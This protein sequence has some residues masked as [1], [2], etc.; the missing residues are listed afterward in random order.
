[1][2][3][4]NFFQKSVRA[5][6]ENCQWYLLSPKNSLSNHLFSNFF[7]IKNRKNVTFTK[8]FPRFNYFH[9]FLVY[10]EECDEC[11]KHESR[12]WRGFFLSNSNKNRTETWVLLKFSFCH[13][14]IFSWIRPSHFF[15][16]CW[17]DL[18]HL[19]LLPSSLQKK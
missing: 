11:K 9:E 5:H 14:S 6:F 10:T 4:R 15:D 16:A 18:S 2:L 19:D 8:F 3:S 17:H 13:N 1:M 7:S 12:F